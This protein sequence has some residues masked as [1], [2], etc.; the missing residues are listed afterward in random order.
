MKIK[1]SPSYG[2]FLKKQG[3][4][5]L[6][7]QLLKVVESVAA[8]YAARYNPLERKGE[9]YQLLYGGTQRHHIS[10]MFTEQPRSSAG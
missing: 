10:Q 2:V 6:S 4:L 3:L 5:H 7:C 9:A 8:E 1:R